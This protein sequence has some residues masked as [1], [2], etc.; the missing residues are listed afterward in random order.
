MHKKPLIG[1]LALCISSL[2]VAAQAAGPYV[3][4]L[5][6]SIETT[7]NV[8]YRTGYVTE[9]GD[10][11]VTES[12]FRPSKDIRA[13]S[14]GMLLGWQFHSSFALETSYLRSKADRDRFDD[15]TT[16]ESR[17]TAWSASA[18]YTLPLTPRW[19]AH[20]RLGGIRRS[21]ELDMMFQGTTPMG[22]EGHVKGIL[23]GA[24]IG[25]KVDRL[26]M[27][28]DL[29]R[30]KLDSERTTLASLGANWHF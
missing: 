6:G 4:V 13:P 14:Y 23:Y 15:A 10:L 27:R 1:L 22:G 26:H 16:V 8:P 24:G 3:G 2:S 11:I 28:F 18:L 25:M 17:V 5:G 9:T 20:A 19:S 7:A 30:S 29:Q 21:H 12:G